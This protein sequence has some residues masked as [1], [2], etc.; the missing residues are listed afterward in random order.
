MTTL[1]FLLLVAIGVIGIAIVLMIINLAKTNAAKNKNTLFVPSA[2]ENTVI[3]ETV[4]IVEAAQTESTPAHQFFTLSR[5]DVLDH[6]EVMCTNPSRFPVAAGIQEKKL[7]KLP[8]YL[9]CGHRCFGVMFE[10]NELIFHFILRMND[11]IAAVLSKYHSV[12][13]ADV[14]SGKN[15]YS[16]IIDNSFKSKRE[17]LSIINDC[18]D[19]TMNISCD[20]HTSDAPA[21]KAEQ[22]I[23]E[24]E[25]TEALEYIE[26]SSIKA[27]KQYRNDLAKFKAEH[28]KDFSITR[29]EIADDVREIENPDIAVVERLKQPQ[30]P[31]SLKYKN[32]TYAM[33]YGTDEGVLMTVKISD[34]YAEELAET[35]SEICRA[36]FP[37][38]PNWYH[39]PIDG[40]F[41]DKESVYRV[42][43]SARTFVKNTT[44][45]WEV[46]GV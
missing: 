8:D 11:D 28:V 39:I 2:G 4:R 6:I 42:L 29:K 27:E 22:A 7:L 38:G 23:I 12:Q 19:F 17:V 18:Y 43:T 15:W 9:L 44:K 14:L 33:L 20:G 40:A 41:R 16:L 32:K 25:I 21:V 31:M 30:L 37:N 45:K 3:R 26:S 46:S 34:D 36:C 35:H 13:R 5:S 10:R 1:T 24:R